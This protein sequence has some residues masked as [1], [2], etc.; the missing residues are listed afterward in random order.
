[1]TPKSYKCAPNDIWALGVVLVNL[2]GNWLWNNPTNKDELYLTYVC[3]KR[4]ALQNRFPV[5]DE[6]LDILVRVLEPNPKKRIGISELR[7]CVSQCSTFFRSVQP[8]PEPITDSNP[9][10]TDK[11]TKSK[12]VSEGKSEGKNKDS[13]RSFFPR[14]RF[15]GKREG[16]KREGER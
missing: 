2:T 5:S 14:F 4:G 16:S 6:L 3:N 15:R 7:N 10:A 12:V 9:A 8:S 1:M 13:L 11:D